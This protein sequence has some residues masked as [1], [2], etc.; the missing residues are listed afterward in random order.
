MSKQGITVDRLMT[1][2]VVTVEMDDSLSV[3]KDIFDNT[4]FHHLLVVN[5]KRLLGVV[6]DRDLLKALSPH[7][8]TAAETLRD[9]RSLDIK[10]HQV[11]TRE[12]I[13]LPPQAS[14]YDAVEVFNREKIS[15]IPIVDSKKHV[16]GILTWRDILRALEKKHKRVES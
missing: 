12:A 15:C 10:V 3:V 11:M 2:T 1:S 16:V 6:S 9:L 14:I 7:L 4:S 5:D 8:G 13:I